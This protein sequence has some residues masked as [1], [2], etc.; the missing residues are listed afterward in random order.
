MRDVF[1]EERSRL[2]NVAGR[3]ST[4]LSNNSFELIDTPLLEETELFARKSGGEIASRLYTFTDPGGRRVSLR[5][6]FT[7]S[8]IR[9][10]IQ[11][12]NSSSLPVRLQYYGPVFRY[13]PIGEDSYRQFT[14]SG[15]E[16]IGGTG[17]DTDVELLDLAQH[18]LQEV[19]LRDFRLRIGDL[20]TIRQLLGGYSLSEAAIHFVISNVTSLRDG[21]T[22]VED[23]LRRARGVGLIKEQKKSSYLGSLDG[24]GKNKTRDLAQELLA[25]AASSPIGRRTPEQIFERL[26][27]KMTEADDPGKL[28]DALE[29][30]SALVG[31]SGNLDS[32][33][34]PV[35]EAA[36]A[37]GLRPSLTNRLAKLL[38]LLSKQ[39]VS[40]N[41]Y[42]FD[43]GLARGISY[44]TGVIFEFSYDFSGGSLLLGGGGRY[45]NL[46]KAHGGK[47]VSAL[48][49]AFTLEEIVRALNQSGCGDS[50]APEVL[51]VGSTDASSSRT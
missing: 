38:G 3:I 10:F 30:A 33:L 15:A 26:V 17:V 45:D 19:G 46:V 51:S 36:E 25:G 1:G 29:L 42:T 12:M 44:Y 16:V 47:D 14:Q 27:R 21:H 23:M 9:H 35:R 8:V 28:R 32:A 13:T 6:E 7:S 20:G 34:K 2:E 37:H 18:T 11:E 43:L 31:I 41:D 5:P 24:S 22:N 50:T 4:H 40:K 48:G 39:A 49:F